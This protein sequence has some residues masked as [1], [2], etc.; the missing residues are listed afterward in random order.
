MIMDDI[1]VRFPPSPTGYLHIGGARTALYNWLFARKHGGKLVLRIED[2]DVE[3]STEESTRG[4]LEGLQW[5]GLDWDEGPYLQS[6][7]RDD[8]LATAEALL[9]RGAAYRCYCSRE[10]LARKREAAMAAK[11]AFVGYDGTCRRLTAEQRAAHEAEGRPSVVRFRVPDQIEGV[12]FDDLVFGPYEVRR[13][14]IDDFVIVRSTG[15]P[16]YI[17]SNVADDHRDRITHVIRGADHLTNTPRQVLIYRA[18]GWPEPRFGH[19]ALTLDPRKAK[20]SKRRHGEVVAVQFYRD[21]G[22]LPW[23]FCNF[24]ALLGWSA[25]DDRELYLDRDELLEAFS[26]EG[27]G[28]S[29]A[30]FNYRPGDPKFI[31]DPKAVHINEQ[32]LRGLP[33]ERLAPHVQRQLEA[34]GIWQPAWAEGGADRRWFLDTVELIRAR[35]HLLTDFVELGRAYF[36]DDFPMADKALNKGLRKDP[37]LKEHLPRLAGR[38]EALPTWDQ[39]ST[40]QALRSLAEELQVKAG[41]LINGARAAVS[42]QAVGP[43]IFDLLVAVGQKRTVQRLRRALELI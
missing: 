42:G 20:I 23:A 12:A 18:L 9:Q 33:V 21:H 7:H 2:T 38:L 37:S 5:M 29:N 15:Q 6:D 25:G 40:E 26:L 16:L 22:F 19:I 43:G 14:E 24:M 13:S 4:I 1:R 28:R 32:H 39:E 3:R 30:V 31:T 8:H 41:L 11:K 10:E 17:L 36:A 35:Y 34:A 27:L